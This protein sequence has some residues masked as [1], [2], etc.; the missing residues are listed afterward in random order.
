MTA[1][2]ADLQRTKVRKMTTSVFFQNSVQQ[3][4][5]KIK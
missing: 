1:M 4:G 3:N 2:V 5:C